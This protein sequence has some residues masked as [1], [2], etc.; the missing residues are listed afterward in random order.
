MS[1]RTLRLTWHQ[2]RLERK[3][4][5]RNTTAAFFGFGL[6]LVFLALFG[7]IFSSDQEALDVLV[8]GIAGLSLMSNTF[9]AL[10]MALPILRDQGV[11]KRVR[12]AALPARAYVGA[13]VASAT[14]NAMLQ[15]AI[16]VIVGRLFFGVG[17]PE[18][19]FQLVLVVFAG[20]ACLASIGIAYSH[21]IPRADAASAY[22]NIVSL[23]VLFI[24]GAFFDTSNTP[25]FLR[26]I[27]QALPL[28]HIIDGFRG[29]MVS[30]KDLWDLGSGLWIVALWTVA[31]VVLAVRGFRWES[32]AG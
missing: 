28:A 2:F 11:L 17:W 3:M 4:F 18:H 20:V 31:G 6:P 12:G 29:A 14:V 16:I 23:P 22:M 1:S 27:A 24:S 25:Q 13:L 30:G 26:D 8:P 9:G 7:V 15:T 5:W 21:V 10:A 32:R 19:P